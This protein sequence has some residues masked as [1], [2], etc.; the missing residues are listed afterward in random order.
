[1]HGL[2][3]LKARYELQVQNTKK[4]ANY[5]EDIKGTI[6]VLESATVNYS[7]RLEELQH[8]QVRMNIK[9]LEIIGRIEVLRCRCTPLRESEIKYREKLEQILAVLTAKHQQ[10]IELM[11]LEVIIYSHIGYCCM[12]VFMILI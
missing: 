9:L 8:K 1:M 4:L 7:T 5:V 11:N 12:Q 6:Q 3:E 2:Q 10:L